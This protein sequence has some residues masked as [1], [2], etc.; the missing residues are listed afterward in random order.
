MTFKKIFG[1]HPDLVISLLNA[2]LPLEPDEE[3]RSIEYL[4][5]EQ[6][7]R[8][9]TGK[10]SIVDVKCRDRVGR[11]F[12]VE[13]QMSWTTEFKRRVVFN[14][15]K[16]Y[17]N[18]LGKGEDYD[19]LHPV[20]SLNIVNDI[21]ER[22]IDEFYH[23]Y[24]LVHEKYTD[25][26]IEGLH[27]VF[28]ELP[29]FKPH[30]ISEKK[31]MVLWLRFLTEINEN[32]LVVPQEMLDDPNVNRAIEIVEESAF[33]PAEMAGYDKFWD[34]VSVEKT[35]INAYNR[36]YD[37]GRAEG[38]AEGEAKGRA[39]GEATAQQAIAMR[40][41]VEGLPIDLI[42]KLTGIDVGAK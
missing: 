7:P 14:A 5:P 10:N 3:I 29:K 25:R 15:A 32:T 40:M 4:A 38:L 9:P 16:A 33:T 39:E 28:V 30:T 26:V 2:L 23:Y 18:Q 27:L 20:Y 19:L 34:D 24:R 41:Q 36:R 6:A 21:F 8:T 1:E 37:M 22:D 42:K 13:M 17:V 35:I 31:M 11:R 12:I